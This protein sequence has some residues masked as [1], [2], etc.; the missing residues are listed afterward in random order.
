[1]SDLFLFDGE[2]VTY[3]NSNTEFKFDMSNKN[4]PLFI[5]QELIRHSRGEKTLQESY[6]R[7]VLLL[8]EYKQLG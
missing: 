6:D 1:M 4:T 7:I 8:E 5:V 3:K 2:V